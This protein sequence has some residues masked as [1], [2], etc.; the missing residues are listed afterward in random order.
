[1]TW[2]SWP[3][4][5]YYCPDEHEHIWYS[6]DAELAHFIRLIERNAG[7]CMDEKLRILR[8]EPWG[9]CRCMV[10]TEHPPRMDE[11]SPC[12][13]ALPDPKDAGGGPW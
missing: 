1:M 13:L 3:P 10:C 11:I 6:A 8:G 2:T 9:Y 12:W 5:T 4:K 7:R